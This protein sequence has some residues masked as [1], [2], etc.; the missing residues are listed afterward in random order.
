[1]EKIGPHEEVK[2][3]RKVHRAAT[4]RNART[5]EWATS[6]LPSTVGGD[7]EDRGHNAEGDEDEG[8]AVDQHALAAHTI[9]QHDARQNADDLEG[10]DEQR[11][12]QGHRLGE[13]DGG[14]QGVRVEEHAVDTGELLEGGDHHANEDQAAPLRGPD[15]ANRQLRA[16][17][18]RQ[19][20]GDGGD[21]CG[22][23]RLCAD[24][25]QD[26]LG[27]VGA[28]HGDQV[29]W[30]L[31]D[32]RREDDEEK[33]RNDQACEENLP[34]HEASE[35]RLRRA[36]RERDDRRVDEAREEQ[37]Q[38]DRELAE[39]DE[40]SA[41]VGWGDLGD[42]AG[43]NRGRRAKTDAA[44]DAGQEQEWVAE[45]AQQRRDWAEEGLEQEE[46]PDPHERGLAA[47]P[48]RDTARGER[49]EQAT[50]DA[51]RAR[52]ALENGAEFE[53]GTHRLDGGVE[54]HALKTVKERAEGGD[55]RQRCRIAPRVLLARRE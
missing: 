37:A 36:A 18:G 21:A 6:G 34:G 28:S 10:R 3:R 29:A 43:G 27:L 8:A 55:D 22:W 50:D 33:R 40:A 52:N 7:R 49:P 53:G 12:G 13:A 24:L 35:R 45:A 38:N 11:L 48:I 46:R 5:G 2:P 4:A 44:N 41:D 26:G 42:V 17:G 32:L 54:D 31:G 51:S 30:G 39:S 9:H 47:D 1:M 14:E 25:R 15:L 23:I 19:R 20:L 16:A